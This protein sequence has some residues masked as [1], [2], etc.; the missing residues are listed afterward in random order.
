MR[1]PAG[2]VPRARDRAAYR[3]V[4]DRAARILDQLAVLAPDADTMRRCEAALAGVEVALRVLPTLPEDVTAPAHAPGNPRFQPAE[5]GLVP[6]YAVA[7]SDGG[8]LSGQVR[9][10]PRFGGTA[11]VHGGALSLFFDDALGRVA[12]AAV[13]GGVA[14]TAFLR[15][16]Y[17]SPAPLEVALSCRV[18][19]ERVE[20]RKGFVRGEMRHGE[21]LTAEAAGLWIAAR[22]YAFRQPAQGCH[23]E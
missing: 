20:G 7:E 19:I 13:T 1:D 14:R 4:V 12:N 5:R 15:V 16:D 9:F 2:A 8:R 17:R 6:A 21:T 10:S 3:R 22:P 11:A 18:W 23:A